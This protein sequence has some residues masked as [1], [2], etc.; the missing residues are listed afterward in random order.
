MR[1]L[2]LLLL[3]LL[4]AA[5]AN[6]WPFPPVPQCGP[7]PACSAACYEPPTPKCEQWV[8]DQIADGAEACGTAG[9]CAP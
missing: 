9:A 6:A 8:A 4:L 7:L 1:T 2:A 5:V 3:A